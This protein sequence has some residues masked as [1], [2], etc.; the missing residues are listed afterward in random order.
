MIMG[1]TNINTED[2]SSADTVIFNDSM[3]ELGLNQYITGPILWKGI[4]L[5]LI[6]TKE[7]SDIQVA[8]CETQ[9]YIS[10]HYMVTMDTNLQKQS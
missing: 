7:K 4:I 6:F 5:D 3:Q 1:D 2:A 10:D 9:T 8:D